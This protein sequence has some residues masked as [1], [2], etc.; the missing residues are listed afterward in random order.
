MSR[1]ATQTA[2]LSLRIPAALWLNLRRVAETEANSAS[3]VARRLI[4]MGLAREERRSG[5]QVEKSR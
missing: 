1:T 4:A 5:D 2:N 3:A